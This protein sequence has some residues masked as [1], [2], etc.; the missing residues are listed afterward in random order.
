VVE[1]LRAGKY[2]DF[3]NPVYSNLETTRSA[4]K[5]FNDSADRYAPL[6]A[7]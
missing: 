6:K 1:Q 7:S 4:L 3:R 5:D 2:G